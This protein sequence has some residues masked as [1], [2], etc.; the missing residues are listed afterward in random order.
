[1]CMWLYFCYV[2]KITFNVSQR[3][4]FSYKTTLPKHLNLL[5]YLKENFILIFLK[6]KH[7]S[8]NDGNDF[9]GDSSYTFLKHLRELLSWHC[10]LIW[11]NWINIQKKYCTIQKQLRLNVA[12]QSFI[13]CYKFFIVNASHQLEYSLAT[14]EK[15]DSNNWYTKKQ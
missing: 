8:K 6:K 4:N 12:A 11:Y 5:S 13:S 3:N 7:N 14:S 10:Y 9:R 1:M 2:E 15:L